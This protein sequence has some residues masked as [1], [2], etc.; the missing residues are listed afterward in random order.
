MVAVNDPRR[1]STV[2]VSVLRE[3]KDYCPALTKSLCKYYCFGIFAPDPLI[4]NA[5][6]L[7]LVL[8]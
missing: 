5:E 6:G 4:I 7:D 2:L 3:E 1:K 8:F